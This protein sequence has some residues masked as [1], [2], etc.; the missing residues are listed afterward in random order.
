[1]WGDVAGAR[2]VVGDYPRPRMDDHHT[3]LLPFP[4][5]T[6]RPATYLTSHTAEKKKKHR[7]KKKRGGGSINGRT[8]L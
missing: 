4:D 5:Q 7:K 8:G 1:V 3:I 2:L 6:D